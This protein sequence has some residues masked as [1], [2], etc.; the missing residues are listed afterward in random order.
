[1]CVANSCRSQM[2][3]ALGRHYLGHEFD[4]YSAGSNRRT[5]IPML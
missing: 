4:V 3:E 5:R 2:A 1:M